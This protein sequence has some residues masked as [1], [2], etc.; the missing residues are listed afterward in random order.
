MTDLP[1]CHGVS[2]G[3]GASAEEMVA[4]NNNG[5]RD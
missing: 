1:G 5:G 2:T 3:H 4:V